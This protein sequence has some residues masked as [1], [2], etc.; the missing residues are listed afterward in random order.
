MTCGPRLRR[1]PGSAARGVGSRA[2]RSP[3]PPRRASIPC[4]VLQGHD[5]RGVP[6]TLTT[7]APTNQP[8]AQAPA[9][10][11]QERLLTTRWMRPNASN[12]IHHRR[13]H[14][15]G[16]PGPDTVEAGREHH[17]IHRG[18]SRNCDNSESSRS[19]RS[20]CQAGAAMPFSLTE[21]E[22][23]DRRRRRVCPQQAPLPRR[24]ET[25]QDHERQSENGNAV[26]E[27]DQRPACVRVG[28]PTMSEMDFSSATSH[29]G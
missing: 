24:Q 26:R 29:L 19:P 20:K 11:E 3:T 15:A 5:R 6:A 1:V 17:A 16:R 4:R 13:R 25:D 14:R 9:R 8:V 21:C 28:T 10:L 27:V 7:S 18:S 22:E 2:S 12:R 23:A